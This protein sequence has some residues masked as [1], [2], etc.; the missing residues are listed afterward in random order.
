MLATVGASS[1]PRQEVLVTDKPPNDVRTQPHTHA[2]ACKEAVAH[3]C[4]TIPHELVK[5]D[6]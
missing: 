5:Y 2:E 1:I 3:D 6:R 4:C